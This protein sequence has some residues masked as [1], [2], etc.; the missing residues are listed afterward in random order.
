V[1]EQDALLLDRA[2]ADEP[3]AECESVGLARPHA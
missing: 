1:A 3:F 2:L